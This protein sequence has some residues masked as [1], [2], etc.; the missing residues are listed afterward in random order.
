MSSSPP[1]LI[2]EWICPKLF[3]HGLAQDLSLDGCGRW[4]AGEEAQIERVAPALESAGELRL[5]ETGTCRIAAA[6]AAL[7][8][9]LARLKVAERKRRK[10]LGPI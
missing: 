3:L 7:R 1:I 10:P 4:R 9:S 5:G 6:E 8:R 2:R